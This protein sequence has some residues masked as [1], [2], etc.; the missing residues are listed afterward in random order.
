MLALL[1]EDN[2][3]ELNVLYTFMYIL[4]DTVLYCTGDATYSNCHD[5]LLSIVLT[6]VI[7]GN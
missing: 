1:L 4:I 2:T 3:L 5:R 7:N 6:N